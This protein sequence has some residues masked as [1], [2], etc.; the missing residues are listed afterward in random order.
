MPTLTGCLRDAATVSQAASPLG[1]SIGIIAAGE[2]C[3]DGSLRPAIE[4]LLGAGSIIECMTARLS[5]DA[6][7]A[8][9]AYRA[10]RD[11]I[12]DVIRDSWSGREL[13]EA[14]FAGD[15][16]IAIEAD[17]SGVA[18]LLRDDAYVDAA[19]ELSRT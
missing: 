17:A 18:P 3:P 19:P 5:P 13:I 4:D 16:E 11:R 15:V 10:L 12:R 8:R 1:L 9:S 6:E 14:A 7:A 2:R